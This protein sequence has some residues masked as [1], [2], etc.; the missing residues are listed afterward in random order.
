MTLG[1]RPGGAQYFPGSLDEVRVWS[2]ARTQCEIQSNMNRQF[3]GPQINLVAYYDCNQGVAGANNAGLTTLNDNSGSANNGMLTNFALNGATSNWIASGANITSVG[4]ASGGYLQYSYPLVCWGASYT[5]PGAGPTVISV[6]GPNTYTS[7]LTATNGCDSMVITTV[8]AYPYNQRQDTGLV[9]SGG[10]YTFPDSTIL[11]GILSTTYYTS[12]LV[13]HRGCDSV[14][15]TEVNVLPSYNYGES[16][17]VCHGGS[18]QFPD[19]AVDTSITAQVIHTSML[20]TVDGC[21]SIIITTVDAYPDYRDSL[22][23]DVCLGDSV[24]F[25]DGSTQVVTTSLVQSSNLASMAG[26]DSL[27]ITTVSVEVVDTAVTI[28]GNVLTANAVGATFVWIDCLTEQPISGQTSASFTPQ[29][30]GNY[31]VIVTS[32]LGCSDTSGCYA[33]IVIGLAGPAPLALTVYPNPNRG[34][35]V[36][37]VPSGLADLAQL[38]IMNA[39]GQV[40]YVAALTSGKHAIALGDVPAGV[41]VL[42][43]HTSVGD[44]AAR[45]VVE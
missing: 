44:A 35:F 31:A 25:P 18:Y 14:I 6:T 43:V 36:L 17:M 9:C 11:T 33:V 4:N 7:N 42:R 38:E 22:T 19:G 12:T 29:T 16:A 37:E 2:T 10:S 34:S 20:Q 24:T 30:T 27:V 8:D 39:L 21:D 5:F 28:A 13:D 32:G 26:C 1:T 45:L 41:Y 40:V 23:L 15:V 3:S